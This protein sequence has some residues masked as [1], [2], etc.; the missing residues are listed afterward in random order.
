M[1]IETNQWQN[2]NKS[3]IG[4]SSDMISFASR[5][6]RCLPEITFIMKIE[7]KKKTTKA[8]NCST[9]KYKVYPVFILLAKW[10]FK[11]NTVLNIHFVFL[12]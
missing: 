8:N 1:Q 5:K 10:E 9:H 7:N 2:L 6:E 12:F 11:A 4:C 3:D